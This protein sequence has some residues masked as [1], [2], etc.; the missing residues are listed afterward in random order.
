MRFEPSPLAGAFV[1]DLDRKDDERGFFARTFCRD[2]FAEHGLVADYPQS[3]VSFNKR[4]GTL[5]GMH[6]QKKPHEEAKIVRCTMGAIY[7]V[8]VDRRPG[9]PTQTRWFGIELSAANRRALYVPKGFAHG[10]ITLAD[11]SEVLYQI[12]T[13]FHPESAA[14]V[15]WNDP[16]FTIEWPVEALVMSGRDR[17]YPDYQT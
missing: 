8:I 11:E 16:A 7:D 4:K 9:S 3:S 6:F 13:Q 1:V 14:G 10:F 12:S 5:R 15:R 2:E 17:S